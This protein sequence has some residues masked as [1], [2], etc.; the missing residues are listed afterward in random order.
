MENALK[1][2][3]SLTFFLDF[4]HFSNFALRMSD[5]TLRCIRFIE[6]TRFA[7]SY[8]KNQTKKPNSQYFKGFSY[9]KMVTISK[10]SLIMK[11]LS[12]YYQGKVSSDNNDFF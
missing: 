5:N 10:N 4:H 3:F 1:Y 2:S 6:N 7:N 11:F 12:V 9:F 8:A